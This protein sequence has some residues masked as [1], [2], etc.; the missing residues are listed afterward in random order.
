MICR[1]ASCASFED[2]LSMLGVLCEAGIGGC[3][4]KYEHRDKRANLSR[5]FHRER[6]F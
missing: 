6:P 1:M 5:A 2:G 3:S 4:R